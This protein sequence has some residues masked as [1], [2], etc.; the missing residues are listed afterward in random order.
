MDNITAPWQTRFDLTTCTAGEVDS[1]LP[2]RAA[3]VAVIY[4]ATEPNGKV[5]LVIESRTG[6]L[7]AQCA[8]RLQTA[9]LPPLSSLKIAYKLQSL[10]DC[11]PAEVESACREQVILAGTIRRELRPA[12]R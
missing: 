8:K 5:F 2:E 1:A 3:G 12:M 11:S 9:N 10:D 4:E 6:S 7:R